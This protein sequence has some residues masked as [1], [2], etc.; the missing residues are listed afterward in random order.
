[1]NPF[2]PQKTAFLFPGQGSQE[3]SMGAGLSESY[4]LAE[5]TFARANAVLSFE[6]SKLAWE[7]PEDELNDTV[8]TQ[9][10]LLVHSVAALRLLQEEWADFQPAFVAGHSMGELSALVAAGA[11]PFEDAVQLARRRGELMKAA[12]EAAPG[13][14]AAIIA[15]DI[16]KT[17]A[18]CMQ[19]STPDEIVQVAND[20]CPGQVVISGHN[21]A[22]DRALPLAEEAGARKVVKLAVSIAA[23]SPLMS[24]A[25]TD[26]NQ[27]VDAAPIETPQVPIIGNVTAKP[28]TTVEHIRADLQAQ[29]N[30]RVRWTESIQYMLEQGVDTF[31]EIGSGDVLTGLVKRID[32]KSKRFTLGTPEDFQKLLAG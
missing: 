10:A 4:P 2:D 1:M 27:A 23:H 32:R 24:Y 28:L 19:A 17:E 26:F 3:V 9:P 31:I 21:A 20:N 25:Q 8:N 18:V 14:M 22:V 7:G 11:L 15:L 12:G 16:P 29:L 30:A 13:G 6:L 5:E